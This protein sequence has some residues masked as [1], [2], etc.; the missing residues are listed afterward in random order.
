MKILMMIALTLLMSMGC[1]ST[2]QASVKPTGE[3]LRVLDG[4]PGEVVLLVF[5]SPDCPISNALSP[6]YE[7]LNEQLREQGGRFYLVH[8]R[9]DVTMKKARAHAR[10]YRLNMSIVLDPDHELVKAM[11]ATVTP[12][13]V[14]LVLEGNGKYRKIYQGQ[15]NNLY[16]SLGNRRDHATEFWT[17]DAIDAAIGDGAVEVAYRKPIG[18]YIEQQR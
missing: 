16:A 8:A 18:C 13:A 15:V 1:A 3:S 12:E 2:Q 10:D 6:E 17:R 5:G 4:Q 11:D 14:V 7:R 9:E